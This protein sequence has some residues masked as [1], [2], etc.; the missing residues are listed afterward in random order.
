MKQNKL[1]S[2]KLRGT[3]ALTIAALSF[4]PLTTS[5]EVLCVRNTTKVIKSNVALGTAL[6]MADT[7]CPKGFREIFNTNSLV[8][9]PGEQGATGPTGATGPQGPTGAPA[10][11]ASTC[12]VRIAEGQTILSNAVRNTLDSVN[13]H[14]QPNEYAL[15][16]RIRLTREYSNDF[17]YTVNSVTNSSLAG[18][19]IEGPWDLT[20]YLLD[21]DADGFPIG[22]ASYIT[23]DGLGFYDSVTGTATFRRILGITCCDRGN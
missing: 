19:T 3:L 10:V 1:L 12:R 20:G 15:A 23:G 17:S 9:T 7:T 8:G 22:G 2:T 16:F 18:Q 11:G 4:I 14:C 21:V 5:A 6:K 13:L